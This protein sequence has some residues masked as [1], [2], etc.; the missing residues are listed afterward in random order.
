MTIRFIY[1]HT[2]DKYIMVKRCDGAFPPK[3]EV[4]PT[5]Y[6]THVESVALLELK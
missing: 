2:P 4:V 6:P 3:C 5:E 1:F